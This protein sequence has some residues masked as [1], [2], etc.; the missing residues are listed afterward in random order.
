MAK[1]IEVND[2]FPAF[3]LPDQD[4]NPV[5]LADEFGKPLVVYFYPK[6]DTP[7]CTKEACSFRDQYE[8][9]T[10]AGAKVFGISS[11][12][13]ASHRKFRAKHNLPFTLLSDKGNAARKQVGVPGSLLGLLPGRVTYIID[14]QG[15]VQQIFN[16]QL[17]VVGHVTKAVDT[18][19]AMN[20][21]VN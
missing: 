9:F 5:N 3:T 21:S 18:I 15:V 6:D 2:K 11:D 17:D 13:S 4:G 16:S 7:G 10:D 14:P 8:F 19:K 12:S 20:Y 1:K